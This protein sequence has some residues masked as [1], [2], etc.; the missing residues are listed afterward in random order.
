MHVGSPSQ[1]KPITKNEVIEFA[2]S[3]IK[4][5]GLQQGTILAWAFSPS[6]REAASKLAAQE[7]TS[8][9]FVKLSLIPIDSNEFKEHITSKHR[10]Y[11]NLLAFILPPEIRIKI[12]RTSPLEYQFD[13]SESIPLNVGGKIM[14]V[15]WDFDY[16]QVFVS[17]K[18]YSF[19]R[20]K[21]NKPELV[22]TYT[23]P[24]KGEYTIACKVQDDL[25]GENTKIE[26][27][28]VS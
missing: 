10:E 1:E 21:N 23:F 24:E 25:G 27:L 3:V 17:T 6:A 22:V 19:I 2:E 4:R 26:K 7:G 13:I 28:E 5:K 20:D 11:A 18:G 16:D 12:K 9:E 8:I 15:Q 14:N